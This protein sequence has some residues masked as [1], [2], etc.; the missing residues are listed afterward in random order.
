MVSYKDKLRKIQFLSLHPDTP[1]TF[2]RVAICS[3]HNDLSPKALDP[4]GCR[5]L[6]ECILI[7]RPT[8]G[9]E[10]LIFPQT[11]DTPRQMLVYMH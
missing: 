5:A 10:E 4:F 3:L 11:W 7:L 1:R 9:I 6:T 2:L 8:Q